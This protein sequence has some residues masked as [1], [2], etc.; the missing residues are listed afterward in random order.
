MKRTFLEW[1]KGPKNKYMT[2]QEW[3]V[4][5]DTGVSS[6]TMW[7]AVNGVETHYRADKPHDP[8]DLGRCVRYV[9]NTGVTNKQ[10]QKVKNMY[11]WW[12]PY[13]EEWDTLVDLF[14]QESS[15][16]RSCPETYEYLKILGKQSDKIRYGKSK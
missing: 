13:I 6:K 12:A 15:K 14:K 4:S 8:S 7:T 10:L 2:Q 16:G 9:E 3:I 5:G 11:P 1:L